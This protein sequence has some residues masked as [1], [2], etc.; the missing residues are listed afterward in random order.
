MVFGIAF[1]TF[2][3]LLLYEYIGW[4]IVKRIIFLNAWLNRII[5]SMLAVLAIIQ[6]VHIF[7][8]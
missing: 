2:T 8:N 3:V 4:T 7:F 1:G 5:G 6:A